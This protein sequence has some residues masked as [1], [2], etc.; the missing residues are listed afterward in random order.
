MSGAGRNAMICKNHI[1]V[2]FRLQNFIR[3]GFIQR[4]FFEKSA[5]SLITPLFYK[6]FSRIGEKSNRLAPQLRRCSRPAACLSRPERQDYGHHRHHH[7]NQ[8]GASGA[9]CAGIAAG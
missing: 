8:S 9:T 5:S 3:V 2:A 4:H 6:G 7:I 1:C